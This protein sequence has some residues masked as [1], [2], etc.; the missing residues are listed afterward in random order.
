MAK[1]VTSESCPT[2][3][4]RGIVMQQARTVFGVMQ[5]QAACPDCSGAGKQFFKDGKQVAN[6]GLEEQSHTVKI[7]VPAGIRTE[8]KIRYPGMGNEGMFG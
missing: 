7:N 3:Q 5:T 8:T 6:G 2:C 1:D 4:G